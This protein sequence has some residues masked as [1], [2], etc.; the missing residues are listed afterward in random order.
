MAM[1]RSGMHFS[2][3]ISV[4]SGFLYSRRYGL[5][6]LDAGRHVHDRLRACTGL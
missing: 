3:D 6:T 5:A 4:M 1:Y 2:C